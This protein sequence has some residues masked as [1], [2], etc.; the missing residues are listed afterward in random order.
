MSSWRDRNTHA[1]TE[2]G[3]ERKGATTPNRN[4]CDI[5]GPVFRANLCGYYSLISASQ[6]GG[7]GG[8]GQDLQSRD[9]GH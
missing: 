8:L 2:A 6:E 1:E 4:H 9:M 7:L 5:K 3:D